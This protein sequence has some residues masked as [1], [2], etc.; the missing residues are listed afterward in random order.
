MLF[1]AKAE[2]QTSFTFTSGGNVTAYG[3]YVGDYKGLMGGNEVKLNCVD[4]FHEVYVG[5]TWSANLT[6]LGSASTGVTTRF[7]DLTL[8]KEAAWLTTQ[9]AGKSAADVGLIQATVWNIFGNTGIA[10]SS[11]W[12]T[13]A[14]QNYSS[15]DFSNYYV[16]T[17]V[18]KSLSSSA[19]EFVMVS[20]PEPATFLLFGTGLTSI[21]GVGIRKRRKGLKTA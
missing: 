4:F 9:Y 17:D 6:N 12:L 2:A 7:S 3:Y 11:Y 1:S 5:E 14:Q 18:N 10:G 20:T 19:Q 8:Y 13:L 21:I 16:V 15:M